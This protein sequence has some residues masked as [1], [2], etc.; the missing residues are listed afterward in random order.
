[1]LNR[2]GVG[3]HLSDTDTNTDTASKILYFVL[4]Q[5]MCCCV[6]YLDMTRH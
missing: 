5:R 2:A 4:V 1:M 6:N 3:G